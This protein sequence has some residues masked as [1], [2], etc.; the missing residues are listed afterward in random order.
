VD[1]HFDKEIWELFETKP[2]APFKEN[3]KKILEKRGLDGDSLFHDFATSAA[4]SGKNANAVSRARWIHEDQPRWAPAT[5][6]RST[7]IDGSESQ[8]KFT[9]NI[10][11]YSLDFYLDGTPDLDEYKGKATA[12]VFNGEKIG[13]REIKNTAS[14]DS[15]IKDAFFADSIMWVFSSFDN[16][17]RIPEIVMDSTLRA[18]PMPWRG[19]GSLCF[20][21]LPESKKFIEIR[22]ARGDL[23]LREPYEKTTHCIN[24]DNVKS[25]MKPGVYRFRAGA[26]GKTEKFIVTY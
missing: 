19:N 4:L 24:A 13:I 2:N 3:L 12:L 23:V 25:S 21:P 5:A 20:T 15:I 7:F 14:V 17:K 10:P 22:N 1:K 6:K 9:P 8:G 26:N 11:L 16:P 18:F